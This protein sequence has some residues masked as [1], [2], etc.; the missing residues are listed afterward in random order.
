[1]GWRKTVIDF[2]TTLKNSPT[3][4]VHAHWDPIADST[5]NLHKNSPEN[6]ELFDLSPNETVREYK[7]DA[8]NAFLPS[9]SVAVGDIWELDLDAVIPFLSQFHS[10]ATGEL[11]HGQEGAFTCLR[12][13]SEDYATIIFRIH[14]EFTLATRRKP[15]WKPGTHEH[16]IDEARFIP[17]QYVGRLLINLKTGVICDFSL[18]LPTRNS[19]LDINDFGY[20]DMVFV[21]CMELFA[22]PTKTPNDIEWEDV[23]TSEEACKRLALKFYKF[24]KI[25][26]VPIEDALELAK[27]TNRPIHALVLFGAL[28]DESC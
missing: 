19:N 11:R 6:V 13:L 5:Y 28:D 1:M 2:S 25:E 12:A 8:F 7:G 4:Q 22:T 26:W 17:A 20:A 3:L 27:V 24:A 14:A 23:I 16:L 15:G 10:G 9:S 21:P 18:A